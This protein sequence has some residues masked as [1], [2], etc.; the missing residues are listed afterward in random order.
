MIGLWQMVA[1][2]GT[3]LTVGVVAL[4][5]RMDEPTP[6]AGAALVA[7]QDTTGK[8]IFTGKGICYACHGADA[9]GTPLAPNLTDATWLN[10]DGTLASIVTIVKEGVAAPKEHPAPMPPMGGAQLTEAEIQAVAQY[11]F[12]LSPRG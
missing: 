10:V 6:A 7:A 1:V 9:K 5:R 3:A 4:E 8:A 2:A 12:S 11:V